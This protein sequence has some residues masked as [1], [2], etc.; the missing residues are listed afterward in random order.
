LKVHMLIPE[1]DFALSA[2]CQIFSL[3]HIFSDYTLYA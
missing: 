1:L 2:P 3:L